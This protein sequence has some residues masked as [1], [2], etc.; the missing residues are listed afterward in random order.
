M[1]IYSVFFQD[2]TDKK[3]SVHHKRT[4]TLPEKFLSSMG[5]TA[6]ENKVEL[7]YDAAKKEIIVKKAE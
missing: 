2:F 4:V 5:V 3:G 1:S 6:T 7:D